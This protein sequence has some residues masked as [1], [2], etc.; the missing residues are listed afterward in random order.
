LG[1]K[2]F[3]NHQ[4]MRPLRSLLIYFVLVFVGGAL[5][6]PWL[7]WCIRDLAPYWPPFEKLAS[8]PFHR[9]VGRSLLGL[10]LLG[11]GP[12]LRSCRMLHCRDLGLKPTERSLS[13]IAFGFLLGFCSLAFVALF[14]ISLGGRSFNPAHSISQILGH[15]FS[16]ILAA[17]IVSVLEEV[18]FRGAL[19]G[20]LRKV[21]SW[22]GA[23]V[24]SSA[25]YAL[26]HFLRKTDSPATVEWFSG[27]TLLPKMFQGGPVFIPTLFT[28]FVAGAILALVY[29]RTGAL[30]FSMGL[31]SGWIFWLKF[32]GFLTVK[33]PGANPSIWGTDA[34]ID[35]WLALPILGC[36]FWMVSKMK[37]AWEKPGGQPM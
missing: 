6:A 27:L 25:V 10:A 13:N 14:A 8:N 24:L 36:V 4:A 16:A 32:Y 34:L 26:A 31:H 5:L 33:V 23:L 1:R 17:I 21:L 28:L 29:Q 7:Y 15:A 3:L 22:P 37:V 20:I 12:L 19:F 30:F 9:F 35:G 2:S 18:L 11:L